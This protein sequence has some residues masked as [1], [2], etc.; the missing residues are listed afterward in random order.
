MILLWR[1]NHLLAIALSKPTEKSV[2]FF[3]RCSTFLYK[4]DINKEPQHLHYLYKKIATIIPEATEQ[5][6]RIFL[7]L[8][9]AS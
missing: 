9:G 3:F 1:M 8:R 6:A 2:G 4:E 7:A 5:S